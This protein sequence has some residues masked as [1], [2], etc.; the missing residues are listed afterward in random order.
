MPAQAGIQG[1]CDAG[2]PGPPLTRGW[3]SEL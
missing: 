2:G 3:R 1:E